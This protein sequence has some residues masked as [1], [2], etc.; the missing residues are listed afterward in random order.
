MPHKIGL[1][2]WTPD[3]HL[4]YKHLYPSAQ[5][6]SFITALKHCFQ[7]SSLRN[8]AAAESFPWHMAE[9]C[10]CWLGFWPLSLASHTPLQTQKRC[11]MKHRRVSADMNYKR[12]RE[13]LN[14]PKFGQTGATDECAVLPQE[15]PP[16]TRPVP[17]P[18]GRSP[19]TPCTGV[20]GR[21]CARRA[22]SRAGST[23][24]ECSTS[25]RKT[26]CRATR[27]PGGHPKNGPRLADGG[28]RWCG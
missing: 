4:S 16:L 2:L 9:I 12:L 10:I 27:H 15:W 19:M 17:L 25:P 24:R 23:P 13:A 14:T 20:P 26:L 8:P 1:K 6:T 18:D 11:P 21:P 28:A 3:E 7:A 22:G 5:R